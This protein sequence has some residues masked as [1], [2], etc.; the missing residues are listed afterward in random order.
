MYGAPV[1]TDLYVKFD[2]SFKLLLGLGGHLD[3]KD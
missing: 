3:P 2:C 1:L